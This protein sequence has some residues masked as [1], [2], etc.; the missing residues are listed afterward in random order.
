MLQITASRFHAAAR[1]LWQTADI[2]GDGPFA[3]VTG[4][5]HITIVYLHHDEADAD[6]MFSAFQEQGCAIACARVHRLVRL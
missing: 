5:G 1:R 2:R 3:V 6:A 4:C